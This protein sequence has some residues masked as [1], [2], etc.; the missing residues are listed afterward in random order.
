MVIRQNIVLKRKLIELQQQLEQ[1]IEDGRERK[2]VLDD[3]I[4][5]VKEEINVS[6]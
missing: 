1:H 6:Y 5:S 4:N 3:Q 2:D